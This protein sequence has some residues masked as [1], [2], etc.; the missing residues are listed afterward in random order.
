MPTR[1]LP[2][3]TMAVA[4]SITCRCV[5]VVQ[6]RSGSTRTPMG[7]SEQSMHKGLQGMA[8]AAMISRPPP[9]RHLP[10]TMMAVA[11]SKIGRAS[12]RERG[13]IWVVAE[14]LKKKEQ[15]VHQEL[16]RI[17]CRGEHS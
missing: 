10:S 14:S 9:T 6:A 15:D 7:S 11:S 3:T 12:C 1:Y 8:S 16:Q 2:V 5:G 17:A 4:S 13:E